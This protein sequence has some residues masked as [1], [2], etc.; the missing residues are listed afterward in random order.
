MAL[1]EIGT[2]YF[3]AIAISLAFYGFLPMGYSSVG[4]S[5]NDHLELLYFS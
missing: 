2:G 4:S 3:C 1:N 5:L